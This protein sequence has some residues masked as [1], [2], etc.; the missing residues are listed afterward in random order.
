MFKTSKE[1]ISSFKQVLCPI[2]YGFRKTRGLIFAPD[3]TAAELDAFAGEIA[4]LD[5][6]WFVGVIA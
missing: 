6:A 5:G 3:A 2:Y 4:P 1:D